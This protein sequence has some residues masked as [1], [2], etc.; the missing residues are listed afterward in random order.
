[1]A[2][3]TEEELQLCLLLICPDVAN[4]KKGGVA[5]IFYI[6]LFQSGHDQCL[7]IYAKMNLFLA[8]RVSITEMILI[9]SLDPMGVR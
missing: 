6:I 7:H 5:S 3:L 2:R 1:M 9:P 8:G 4:K